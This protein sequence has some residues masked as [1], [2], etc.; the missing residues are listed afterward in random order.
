MN[1]VELN[2]ASYYY[3][4]H[5]RNAEI[6]HHFEESHNLNIED[7]KKIFK[8]AIKC[9]HKEVALYI[10]E[11]KIQNEVEIKFTVLESCLHYYNFDFINIDDINQSS[12]FWLICVN[13]ITSS[14]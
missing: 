12:L 11:N 5:G 3:V 6:I 8:K 10:L 2:E 9:H 7:Y 14:F 1:N 13:L 4:V